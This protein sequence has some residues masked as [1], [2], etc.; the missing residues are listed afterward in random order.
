MYNY[1]ESETNKSLLDTESNLG[2]QGSCA[3]KM[4]LTPNQSCQCHFPQKPEAFYCYRPNEKRDE[5]R[6]ID[7]AHCYSQFVR[8]I[9]DI[10]CVIP[11][12]NCKTDADCG[13]IRGKQSYCVNINNNSN[14]CTGIIEVSGQDIKCHG[15]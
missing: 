9:D 14:V 12:K 8:A 13:T 6:T 1:K 10:I 11:E 15:S 5:K 4:Q 3:N 7:C 2:D